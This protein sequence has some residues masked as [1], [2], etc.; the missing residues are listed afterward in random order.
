MAKSGKGQQDTAVTGRTVW[1]AVV[2]IAK[3]LGTM[4]P[5]I[6]IAGG[7]IFAFYKFQ[8][9]SQAAQKD[10]QSARNEASRQFQ[11]ELEAANK[12]LRE[13]YSQMGHL[14]KQQIENVQSSLGLH[15]DVLKNTEVQR[16]NL[17]KYQEEAKKEMDNAE[18]ARKEV[19]IAQENAA[20]QRK[21]AEDTKAELQK[22][23]IRAVQLKEEQKTLEVR[24]KEQKQK[25]EGR[26]DEIEELKKKLL[27]L[28]TLILDNSAESLTTA[29]AILN[30]Y[31][32]PQIS[33]A[34]HARRPN[35]ETFNS[36][37][38]LIGIDESTLKDILM[39]EKK[40]QIL[41]KGKEKRSSDVIYI[42]VINQD[43][44]L[45][46][47]I[48]L[49]IVIKDRVSE[50]KMAN[51]IIAIFDYDWN[52]WYEKKSYL[53]VNDIEKNVNND[54]EIYQYENKFQRK[55]WTLM[56]ALESMEEDSIVEILFGEEVQ[57]IYLNLEGFAK[58]YPALYD[59]MAESHQGMLLR[60]DARAKKFNISTMKD[61]GLE[62]IPAGLREQFAKLLHFAVQ[63]DLNGASNL[64][65]PSLQGEKVLGTVAAW[66]LRDGFQIV[67]TEIRQGPEGVQ[68]QMQR[69]IPDVAETRADI[70]VKAQAPQYGDENLKFR[71]IKPSAEGGWVLT[72]VERQG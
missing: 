3:T 18:K 6:L 71:F 19:Q 52:N 42:C 24:L 72:A 14:S 67:S 1:D 36:L 31:E 25:V 10:V 29:K 28:A 26:I 9:L 13:T 21:Q 49:F 7:V 59:Q 30:D 57:R 50:I 40:Y 48:L 46:R 34:E 43:E 63:H 16:G 39:K 70:V 56:S 8:E 54:F 32:N 69:P 55:T 23:S 27:Q 45:Y 38:R 58:K 22:L 33:L 12:A 35:I 11:A 5:L 68:Q 47:D 2:E 44:Y 53:I 62:R 17:M 4:V 15:N 60:M 66:T 65:A 41:I 64:L 37:K 51:N 20:A 61:A